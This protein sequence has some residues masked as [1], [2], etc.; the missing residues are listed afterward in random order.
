MGYATRL[1]RR[2]LDPHLVGLLAAGIALVFT[3]GWL[4]YMTGILGLGGTPADQAF[5]VLFFLFATPANAYVV[6]RLA[7][8]WFVAPHSGLSYRRATVVGAGAA[9]VSYLTLSLAFFFAFWGLHVLAGDAVYGTVKDP[10][11]PTAIVTDALLVTALGLVY[12]V[13]LT[14]GLPVVLT[15]GMALLLARWNRQYGRGPDVG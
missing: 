15:V 7:W 11:T 12:G 6:I 5:F 10:F 8:R 3:T 14:A 1:G 13:V 4:L 2:A 9:L